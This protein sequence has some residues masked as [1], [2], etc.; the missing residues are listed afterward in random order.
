MKYTV[1]IPA[2]GQ[3]KRM[4]AGHN[5]QFL[6]LE[7]R[8]LIVH[9]VSVFEQ[10]TWCERIIVVANEDETGP[11]NTLFEQWNFRK[12]D[13]IVTGGEERQDSVFE[14][15]KKA[16]G[17]DD[18]IVLVHDGARP[19]VTE[20][21][22]HELVLKASEQGAAVIGLRMKDTVKKVADGVVTETIERS[23]V[24]SVQTPQAFRFSVVYDAYRK[25]E[26]D[27]FRGTDDTSLVERMNVSVHIVEGGY[28]NIKLTTPE[29]MV[30]AKAI[31]KKRRGKRQ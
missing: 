3:G 8:P 1:V 18:A 28:D 20:D 7:D 17:L 21:H 14:G 23:S 15:L 12:V 29:D 19:F 2:A 11:M 24:W 5:K 6:M 31:L 9:T 25:A 10:D 27:H 22:I 30:V 16:D 26:E 13:R 4:K